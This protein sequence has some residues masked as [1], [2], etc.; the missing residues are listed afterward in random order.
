[1]NGLNPVDMGLGTHCRLYGFEMLGHN[2]LG[3]D[4]I[5]LC[6]ELIREEDILHMRSYLLGKLREDADNLPSF[7]T[8][9]LTDSVVRLHHLCGFNEDRLTRSRLVMDDTF[10]LPFHAG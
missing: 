8:L 5:N 9:Q 6:Q 7:L 4:E 2:G 10:D 1:M 3:A